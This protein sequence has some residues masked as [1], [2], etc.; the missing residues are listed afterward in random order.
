[1]LFSSLTTWYCS[2]LPSPSLPRSALLLLFLLLLF[3][4]FLLLLLLFLLLLLLLLILLLPYTCNCRRPRTA[5]VNP[6]F[7]ESWERR[8]TITP[9]P[10][11]I[12]PAPPGR[13]AVSA[14]CPG[15]WGRVWVWIW[16]A[17]SRIERRTPRSFS[18]QRTELRAE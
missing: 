3:P 18:A 10:I 15:T 17:L 6:H 11:R 5:P 4:L 2:V 13:G 7:A 16:W 1:M 12:S 9:V 8:H 14:V